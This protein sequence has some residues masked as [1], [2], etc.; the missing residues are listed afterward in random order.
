MCQVH[1]M[2]IVCTLQLC[3]DHV[4]CVMYF[5]TLHL[6]CCYFMNLLHADCCVCFLDGQVAG[7][8]QDLKS[9]LCLYC[10]GAYRLNSSCPCI[11]IFSNSVLRALCL[12]S[13]VLICFSCFQKILVNYA[14]I[15]SDV[16]YELYNDLG[17]A[18]IPCCATPCPKLVSV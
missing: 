9:P 7:L 14:M 3:L 12:C 15:R 13:A 17:G 2:K 11:V 18:W 10:Y 4:C 6:T 16:V 8:L 5:M 1:F